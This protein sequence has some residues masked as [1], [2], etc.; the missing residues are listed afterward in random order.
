V[1][2]TVTDP[3]DTA[4]EAR[5]IT[6]PVEGM[7]CAACA[8]RIGKVLS[9]LDGVEEANVNYATHRARVTYV[10]GLVDVEAMRARVEKAGYHIPEVA[11]DERAY[12]ERL[13]GLTRNLL[14]AAVFTVPLLLIS[15]VPALMFTG[16]QWAAFALTTPVVLWAGREFHRNAA[17]NLRHGQVTMDT[18]V[19]MGTLVAYGWSVVSLLFLGAGADHGGMRLNIAGL[20]EVYFETAGAII[21]FILLGR[22][23]EHR[24]KGRSSQAIRKLLELGARTATLEDGREV[25]VEDLVPGDRVVVRPGDRIPADG[26]VADGRSAV[27]T[28]MLTGEPVP[29]EKGPGD[30]VV[31]GTVNE[32]GRLVVEVRAVG[33]D[34]VLA[35]IVDLVAEAQ[36][37]KA[38]VQALVDRVSAVFVPIVIAIAVGTLAVSLGVLDLSLSESITRA[39]AVLVIAC[40]CALGLATPTAIMVGTGRGASLGVLIKGAEVLEGARGIDT[41][42]L[43]KTGTVTEGRM[44]LVDRH[45]LDGADWTLP[46][47]AAA[48]D[49]SNH[50]V[51]RA[52]AAGLRG[53]DRLPEPTS[54]TEHPGRGVVAEVDGHTVVVGRRTLLTDEGVDLGRDVLDLESSVAH[55]GRT[56]VLAAVDGRAVAVL[57]IADA[58]KATSREAVAA[59]RDLGL[60]T[61]LVTGDNRTTAEAVAAEVGID[62]VVAE[63]LPADKVDVVTRLQGEGRVVAMV[64]DGVND[65]PA[66]AQADLG[67]AMGTGTDIAIE[68]GEVT[69]VSGD[70]RAAADAVALSRRTLSTI[71][72]NLV[73]AF[74]YNVLAIPLAA[75]GLLNPMVAAAAMGF[76]SVF[77]VTN[78]LRLRDFDGLRAAPTTAQ[79]V[80]RVALRLG[81]AVL[82][83]AVLWAGVT[84][85]RSLLPGRPV[86]VE[87][88]GTSVEVAGGV[89]EVRPGEKVTFDITNTSGAPADFAL[90]RAGEAHAGAG[91]HAGGD[92]AVAH[93]ADLPGVTGPAGMRVRFTWTLPDPLPDDYAVAD[94]LA[95]ASVPV[96]ATAGG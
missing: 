36:G 76:S 2:T 73:W 15:M 3:S 31:G 45:V 38:P 55:A 40:P 1:A 81:F 86:A 23:F 70:L 13:Q 47:V 32:S 30:D 67:L 65:A 6:L 24:A 52:V 90:V 51:A 21:A 71:R 82:I 12:A 14:V 39:V 84:F 50:P 46:L 33:A 7:T 77:V 87:L 80:E 69:L 74:G 88:T 22:Y 57:A 92:V 44:A 26:V 4:G 35:Q 18:L 66:L 42:V 41:I 68:A 17:L 10:P 54:V 56:A 58:V 28:S 20:P 61:L 64:G 11:D 16:W 60:R 8:T 93:S 43:D 49:A 91:G 79:R 19:S 94:T 85:Q 5:R 83:A 34:S 48:E 53:D 37:G 27:D 62:E 96:V 63:V 59:F 75:A 72:S 25:P 9:K 89:V 29:V 95:D 78:S